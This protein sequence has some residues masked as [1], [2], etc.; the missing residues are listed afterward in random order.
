MRR[1]ATLA[2]THVNKEGLFD[3]VTILGDAV[4]FY[5][6]GFQL[7][8]AEGYW[9]LVDILHSKGKKVFVDLKFFD[10]PETVKNA[11]ANL[12]RRGVE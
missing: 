9:D 5:K 6:L 2:V 1:V 8:M 3:S 10:V 12:S 4:S 11:V 7:F